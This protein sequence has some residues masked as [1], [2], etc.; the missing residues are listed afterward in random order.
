MRL[1]GATR[2]SRK[3]DE[4]TS[5]ERQRE[6]ITFTA[7][8]RGDTLVHI[9]EDTDVSGS[10]DPFIRES[11]GPWL[12]DPDKIRQWDGLIVAK[13]DRLTRSLSD[14]D[15]LCRW[16]ERNGKILISVAESID[17]SSSA[18]R[19]AATLIA[20]FAQFERERM[21]ERR[22]ESAVK[23]KANGWFAGGMVP[24]GFRPVKVGDHREL[25]VD[26][27]KAKIVERIADAII[28]GKTPNAIAREL[29]ADS[30]AT[31]QGAPKWTRT[32]VRRIFDNERSVLASDVL[33]KVRNE[34]D[35]TQRT[36]TKRGDAAMLLNV[37]FCMCGKPL[38]A[39]RYIKRR[40]KIPDKLYTYYECAEQCGST[41]GIP[42]KD[43]EN[44]VDDCIME[45]Y[46][47]V[48]VGAKTITPGKSHKTEIAIIERQI[49]HLDL[50]EPDYA[51]KHAE[52][53][54][55]R[56]RLKTL[57]SE[58]DHIETKPIGQTTA[59]YWPTLDEQGKRQFLLVNFV[60]KGWT[61]RAKRGAD[62]N[63]Y[64]VMGPDVE[65]FMGGEFFETVHSLST[66]AAN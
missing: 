20:T 65:T 58:P 59:D 7:K 56:A 25:E 51:S 60:S 6:Q 64:P 12:T 43:L 11:L 3:S 61:V 21:S 57:P 13:L 37:A 26:P 4:S 36:F 40:V 1:L 46:G 49:R 48:E 34:L 39:K 50:D 42:Q 54:A 53:L 33:L 47:W 29:T 19:M 52:L 44:A 10:V 35:G 24:Y 8:V 62:G 2:L 30:I 45:T 15:E 41:R 66:T 5:I 28:S 31:P 18:G 38:Y 17:L 22:K 32:T 55:E 63:V 23:M 9:T 27:D 14:F 16:C